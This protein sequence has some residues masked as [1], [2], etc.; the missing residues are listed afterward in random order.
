MSHFF[1]KKYI[2]TLF[3]QHFLPMQRAFLLQKL[4][5]GALLFFQVHGNRLFQS[6]RWFL[7]KRILCIALVTYQLVYI[8]VRVYRDY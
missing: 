7:D 6:T 5:V 3:S 4:F 1:P 2:F 8:Q